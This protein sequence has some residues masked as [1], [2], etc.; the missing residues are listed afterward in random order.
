MKFFPC[1]SK[2]TRLTITCLL[3][4]VSTVSLAEPSEVTELIVRFKTKPQALADS[5]FRGQAASATSKTPIYPQDA[6]PLVRPRPRSAQSG[7][8]RAQSLGSA[9]V[10]SAREKLEEYVILKYPDRQAL[11]AAKQALENDP[12]VLWVG[13]NMDFSLLA[14]PAD[15]LFPQTGGDW[16]HQWGLHA[17]NLP[18]AWDY[19][20]GHAYVA[21]L[22]TG[23]DTAHPDL[24]ANFRGHFSYDFGHNDDNVD[25]RQANLKVGNETKSDDVAFGVAPSRAG[26]GTHVAGILAATANNVTG[27]SG[28][29]WNCSLMVGKAARIRNTGLAPSDTILNLNYEAAI[30]GLLWMADTG[31]Q[32]INMSFGGQKSILC[33][34]DKDD[35]F[36]VALDHAQAMDVVMVAAA[37]N[38]SVQGV[39]YPAAE[40]RVI[41]V[42]AIDV[43]GQRPFWSSNGP[44]KELVA[45]GVHVLST[46][47]RGVEYMPAAY[48][49]PYGFAAEC[50]DAISGPSGYGPCSG[51]SMATPHISGSA[52]LLRSVNPLLTSDQIRDLLTR[53]ANRTDNPDA[54]FGHGLPD[55]LKSVQSALG[56]VGGQT[57][58]NRLTPLFN[59]YSNSAE[60]S[61]YTTSPQMAMAAMYETLQPQPGAGRVTWTPLRGSGIFNYPDFPRK[62]GF[63]FERPLAA[64]YLFTTHRNPF[65]PDKELVPL[66]R[67]SYRGDT[68]GNNPLNMDHVYTTE[69]LGVQAYESLGYKLDG[70]EGYIF[71][72]YEPQPPGTVR[73]YRKYNP[74]R[75][76]HA[77]FPETM[78]AE[79]TSAGYTQNSGH[80]WI[81]Y[82]YV[83]NDSDGDG[84]IDGFEQVIG[85]DINNP[86]SDHDGISD[87]TEVND[88]PYS[89]PLDNI[90]SPLFLHATG[91]L[92]TSSWHPLALSVSFADAPVL[93]SQMQSF[94]GGDPAAIRVRRLTNRGLEIKIEE[95]QSADNETAHTTE[96]AGLLGLPAGEIRDSD[97]N[98]IGEAG[99]VMSGTANGSDWKRLSF[100]RAYSHPVVLMEMTTYN[101]GQ[102]AHVR[103]KEVTG[104]G[105][106][107]QIEEWDY[108]DES[109]TTETLAYV[110]LEQGART[111]HD[112]KQ[113]R[114]GAT[115]ANHNWTGVGF[116]DIGGHPTVF[117]QSQTYKGSQAVVTR[118]RNIKSSGFQVR[119]QEEEGNDGVHAVE[120]VGYL[121]IQ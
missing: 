82:V 96:T 64:A 116:E 10:K 28:I 56:T 35:P 80:E 67:L 16:D 112:G 5:Q 46:F 102:P 36:C 71:P 53:H 29:C 88:Y 104:T 26:H 27:G 113:V 21:M 31:A 32:V 40:P 94:N 75:D 72:D 17:L 45:P 11:E 101:G 103:L 105:A 30:N 52:A 47:Y 108:L 120:T 110:V 41:A 50:T 42:G 107:Y 39:D 51:T 14:A 98:V 68:T 43:N 7:V 69:Q 6:R 115:T 99:F 55:M 44:E 12:D 24:L 119:L 111:L 22:D 37:G 89:D 74:A 84:L 48:V 86:D 92:I 97:G 109:H 13:E 57:L 83:N 114:V 62:A 78:L 87:G 59:L 60:D 85:T 49:D 63:W 106:Q 8:A 95:E 61:F 1:L 100:S 33:E 23:I 91:N 34:N 4:S 121:A 93:L 15:P 79:M 20:R 9:Q 118:H 3:T 90:A 25:E 66:Y 70:I 73:L 19:A 81:G 117:T 54:E 2:F 38:E 65:S 77:I 18:Q 76:D 58:V